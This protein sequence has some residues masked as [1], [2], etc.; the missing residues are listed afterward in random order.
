MAYVV[1][2]SLFCCAVAYHESRPF[3]HRWVRYPWPDLGLLA[4]LRLL[5]VAVLAMVVL[6]I[7][8]AA[9]FK[10]R[11]RFRY[12]AVCLVLGG[13]I[14]WYM[15]CFWCST[16]S[17]CSSWHSFPPVDACVRVGAPL[18]LLLSMY[19]LACAILAW[20]FKKDG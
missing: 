2:L 8:A 15:A 17:Y 11:W 19:A 4:S 14:A 3:G 16:W 20:R 7:Y 18:V 1:A 10:F 5:W 13:T 6:G 9:C 12:V